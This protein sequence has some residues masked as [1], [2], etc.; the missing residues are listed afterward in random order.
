MD[1]G[2]AN[3]TIG[4]ARCWSWSQVRSMQRLFSVVSNAPI[5]AVRAAIAMTLLIK[6][7]PSAGNA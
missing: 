2:D 3:S 7:G 5:D 1:V 6:G 4:R